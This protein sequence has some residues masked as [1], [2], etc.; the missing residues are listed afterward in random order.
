MRPL[1]R[2]PLPPG[3]RRELT[4]ELAPDIRELADLI[5]RDL[6]HWLV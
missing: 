4:A 3:L 2:E 5:D 1:V 6:S